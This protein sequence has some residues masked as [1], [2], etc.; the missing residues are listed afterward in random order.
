MTYVH[1]CH[2][3][4]DRVKGE[5]TGPSKNPNNPPRDYRQFWCRRCEGVFSEPR[6]P[7]AGGEDE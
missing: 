2:C 5:E 4:K 7:S 3:G 1:G 6:D